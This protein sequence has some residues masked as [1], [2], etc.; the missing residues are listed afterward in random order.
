MSFGP[1]I[2]TLNVASIATSIPFYEN[3]LG[4]T[5][6]WTWS[7]DAGFSADIPTMACIE[8]G[9]AVLFLSEHDGGR[10]N[11]L[12]IE[13]TVVAD[14]DR[15]A[16]SLTGLVGYDGPVDRPWGSR[17]ITLKDPDGHSYRFSCPVDR[18]SE[19]AI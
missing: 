16:A 12:F 2:P 8:H 7:R 5:T 13:L 15:L 11:S 4:F 18:I 17:E 14:V 9:E 6:K 19:V 1:V 3:L 10:E